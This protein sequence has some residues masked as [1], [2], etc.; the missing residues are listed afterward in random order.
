MEDINYEVLKDIIIKNEYSPVRSIKQVMNEYSLS[1]DDAKNLIE[2]ILND[3]MNKSNKLSR[4]EFISP[5]DPFHKENMVNE[6]ELT[7]KQQYKEN[8]KAG[9]VSCPKC[10]STS[11]T[12]TNKKLSASRGAAGTAVGGLL[13]NVPGAVAGA[14]VGSLSSKKIY[15]VCMNCGHR[16]KP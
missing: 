15:N 2:P 8:K 16:W 3:L 10:G 5:Y 11:I 1:L 13:G 6:K 4:K 9:I 12:T 14:V 7:A